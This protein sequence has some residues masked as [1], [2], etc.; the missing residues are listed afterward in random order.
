M[1]VNLNYIINNKTPET[2]S[3]LLRVS[4]VFIKITFGVI[5]TLIL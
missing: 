2:R 1:F 5:D 4:G 3:N